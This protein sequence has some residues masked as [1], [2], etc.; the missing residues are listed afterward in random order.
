MLVLCVLRQLELRCGKERVEEAM[1]SKGRKGGPTTSACQHTWRSNITNKKEHVQSETEKDI[2][3]STEATA[4][5]RPSSRDEDGEREIG[6]TLA[7][8]DFLSIDL[9][10]SVPRG[11][12]LS[13]EIPFAS[14]L[15]TGQTELLC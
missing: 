11:S 5:E 15:Y 2:K 14:V 4:S 10:D 7:S 8:A 13:N 12:R 6:L 3:V 1:A 9:V